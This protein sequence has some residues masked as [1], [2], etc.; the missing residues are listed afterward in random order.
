ME[1][2]FLY[3]RRP[4]LRCF[5]W[6]ST[7]I[8]A[9]IFFPVP[10]VHTSDD[11]SFLFLSQIVSPLEP[12]NLLVKVFLEIVSQRNKAHGGLSAPGGRRAGVSSGDQKA[13]P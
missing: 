8:E 4:A 3:S 2:H 9:E 7:A 5:V 6:K 11:L 1:S 12:N 10:F 13:N